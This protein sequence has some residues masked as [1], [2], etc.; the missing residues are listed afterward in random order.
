[1]PAIRYVRGHVLLDEWQQVKASSQPHPLHARGILSEDAKRWLAGLALWMQQRNETA[2]NEDARRLIP[3]SELTERLVELRL[4]AKRDNNASA[5][6]DDTKAFINYVRTRTG[7]LVYR[8]EIAGQG[9][10][11]FAHLSFQ[12]VLWQLTSFPKTVR[13]LSRITSNSFAGI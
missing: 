9:Q 1:M 3:E 11:A 2:K 8:G 6:T 5:A 7:L 4:A 12:E 13:S 10:F